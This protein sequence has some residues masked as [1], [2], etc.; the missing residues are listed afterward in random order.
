ME[1][2][3][4]HRRSP[5]GLGLVRSA[6]RPV[7]GRRG[8]I[9]FVPRPGPLERNLLDQSS[10][11]EVNPCS[12]ASC[13]SLSTLRNVIIISSCSSAGGSPQPPRSPPAP[14]PVQLPCCLSKELKENGFQ[15][16][17]S[18]P[19][20]SKKTEY[21]KVA[22]TTP[23]QT[24]SSRNCVHTTR[25][26]RS[27][28]RKIPLLPRRRNRLRLP[29]PLKVGYRVTPEH[30]DWEK[31]T[32][33]RRINRKLQGESLAPQGSNTAQSFLSLPASG[34][35][36]PSTVSPVP[37]KKAGKRKCITEQD[38]L[39]PWA[40]LA[41]T[42]V[43]TT[44]ASSPSS[45]ELLLGPFSPSMATASDSL[46]TPAGKDGSRRE[47]LAVPGPSAGEAL[48][49]R[50]GKCKSDWEP[51]LNGDQLGPSS[52]RASERAAAGAGSAFPAIPSTS[53]MESLS[54]DWG[55]SP[56]SSQRHCP[57]AD[58][59]V[60][61]FPSLP[62]AASA[63]YD[64]LSASTSAGLAT[65]SVTD[66]W[67]TP[68]DNTSLP[69]PLLP[70]PA[71]SSSGSSCPSVQVTV[72]PSSSS[73]SSARDASTLPGLR[74]FH[75]ATH[76]GNPTE[77]ASSNELMSGATDG[78]QH[79]ATPSLSMLY[80][81]DVEA[82]ALGLGLAP[83]STSG[84]SVLSSITQAA[85]GASLHTNMTS[86]TGA[87]NQLDSSVIQGLSPAGSFIASASAT[88]FAIHDSTQTVSSVTQD[89]SSPATSITSASA[90]ATHLCSAVNHIQE[91]RQPLSMR[92]KRNPVTGTWA[93]ST[94][95]EGSE[96][97]EL[98][99]DFITSFE[100][101]SISSTGKGASSTTNYHG[102]SVGLS[103]SNPM[104]AVGPSTM[105]TSMCGEPKT[106]VLSPIPTDPLKQKR[107][108]S[109]REP[110]DMTSKAAS[111]CKPK[112]ASRSGIRA[113]RES[114]VRRKLV[115]RVTSSPAQVSGHTSPETDTESSSCS[116]ESI[117]VDSKRPK[118]P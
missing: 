87:S 8:L 18:M 11:D 16:L 102:G 27:Q 99:R 85:T 111:K 49:H 109:P 58:P 83:T 106:P 101:L 79:R 12:Q 104:V 113:A 105:K 66:F 15:S 88:T 32:A 31:E 77:S 40:L 73:I 78:Q 91:N 64:S 45:S 1:Q 118:L 74:F 94:V 22:D 6:F 3:D 114:K 80:F 56:V 75:M 48:L 43:T 60:P 62:K 36:P 30:L 108:N 10:R 39:D 67:L 4:C 29:P 117:S 93:V 54:P 89:L 59:G 53:K 26:A 44:S 35:A 71:A 9:P 112:S 96:G 86:E 24:K 90:T 65:L 69:Q 116:S 34:T 47:T 46:L 107:P 28:K 82:M 41:C 23:R 92:A 33:F 100:A 17:C 52:S 21:E 110:S 70:E 42:A 50:K 38:S 98:P 97:E 63:Q 95:P 76:E 61:F 20:V 57:T 72:T 115:F 25:R 2:Q 81:G 7:V 37:C 55:S 103:H 19:Q 13:M 68:L 5:S 84:Q 14:S 51:P